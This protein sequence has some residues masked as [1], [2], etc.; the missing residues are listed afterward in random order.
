M[1]AGQVKQK[2]SIRQ[3]ECMESQLAKREESRKAGFAEL[4]VH[5]QGGH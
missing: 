1:L 5:H 3:A 4:V 2:C